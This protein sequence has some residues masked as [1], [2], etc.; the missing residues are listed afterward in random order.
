M[1]REPIVDGTHPPVSS[2]ASKPVGIAVLNTAAA[3]RFQTVANRFPTILSFGGDSEAGNFGFQPAANRF[4]TVS[5]NGGRSDDT[6][7]RLY[8]V[9]PE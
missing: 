3:N 7:Y 5:G 6:K 2:V 4:E 1:A 8:L 9:A